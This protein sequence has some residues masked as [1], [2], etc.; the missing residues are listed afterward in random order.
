MLSD[1]G[2]ATE[3]DVGYGR[4]IELS[5]VFRGLANPYQLLPA[6]IPGDYSF[7]TEFQ[8]RPY[9]IVDLEAVRIVK[10]IRVYNRHD[11][12]DR[13]VPMI[14]STSLD[15][16]IWKEISRVNYVFGGRRNQLPLD[17]CFTGGHPRLRYVKVQV[18]SSTYLNLDYIEILAPAPHFTEGRL[19]KIEIAGSKI[20]AEY[21]H[22]HSFGF[23]WTFTV[24][25][26]MVAWCLTYGITITKIDYSKCLAS[27]K[28][29]P[30]TDIYPV[31]FQQKS[32][33]EPGISLQPVSFTQHA[34]YAE[35]DLKSL[36]EYADIYFTPAEQVVA[37]KDKLQKDY[38]LDVENMIALV[39]RGT[40]KGTEVSPASIDKYI[41][42]ALSIR[43]RH[44]HLQIVI[45]TDQAQAL[46]AVRSA[47]PDVIYFRE[48]P[49]TT[50]SVVMYMLPLEEEFEIG[51]LEF[52]IRMLAVTYLLSS[53]RYLV[54]HT[55]NIGL[56]LA[57]YRGHDDRFYQFDTD[58]VMRG[59]DGKVVGDIDLDTQDL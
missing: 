23:S 24:T 25:L 54:T 43:Y 48:M 35:L 18:E 22:H 20:L 3:I 51:K 39:Y 41:A 57:I 44:P 2:N 4:P 58:T 8:N 40:D 19:Q 21:H 29:K 30:G 55:G 53:A 28:D 13:S 10:R 6:G 59:K 11:Y 36:K 1:D 42:A 17:I 14:I 37:F 47:I 52:S 26:S 50:G 9:V 34:V 49:V 45:Q 38:S 31:L 32:L 46:E 15:K 16:E 12:A 33:S 56:W 5:S 27:F 7:H